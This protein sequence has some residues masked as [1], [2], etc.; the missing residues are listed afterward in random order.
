MQILI[1]KNPKKRC[2]KYL[3]KRLTIERSNA[4][5]KLHRQAMGTGTAK[6]EPVAEKKK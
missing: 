2:S 5:I 3:K 6:A 4:T 1:L